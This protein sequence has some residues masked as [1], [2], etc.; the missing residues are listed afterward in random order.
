MHKLYDRTAPKKA[1]NLSVNS[2]LLA[3][4]RN[5]KVNLSATLENALEK[6]LRE[7]KRNSWLNENKQA[8]KNCN[9]LTEKYGLFADKFRAF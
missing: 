9:G 3:E 1:T 8:I 7:T 6:E 4:A 5:L 2:S